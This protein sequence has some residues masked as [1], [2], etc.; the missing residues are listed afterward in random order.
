[1]TS[2]SKEIRPTNVREV[3]TALDQLTA[4]Q[5]RELF[6]RL[7]VPLRTL[8]DIDADYS[9]GNKRKTFYV[10]AW[11]DCETDATW[12]KIVAGLREIRQMALA[13]SLAG[14]KNHQSVQVHHLTNLKTKSKM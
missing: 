1:M 5:T 2:I 10:Q 7:G 12:D 6:F 3:L 13:E 4:S 8:D 9:Q 11:Y 14:Q